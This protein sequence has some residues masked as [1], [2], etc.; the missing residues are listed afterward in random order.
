MNES[1]IPQKLSG[2]AVGGTWMTWYFSHLAQI[3]AVLQNI[4]L[5]AAIVSSILAARF[6]ARRTGK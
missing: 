3:N 5:V 2:L 6:Y 4:A 1:S